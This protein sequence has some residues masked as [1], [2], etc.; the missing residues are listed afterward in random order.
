MIN[1]GGVMDDIMK[2]FITK[3]I[4]AD[5]NMLETQYNTINSYYKY[6]LKISVMKA[7]DEGIVV[8]MM[9][10]KGITANHKVPINMPFILVPSNASIKAI[11][12]ID[13]YASIDEKNHNR[14]M[15]DP[16]KLYC[17]LESAFVARGLQ[18]G[19]SSVRHNTILY[20]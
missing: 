20:F 4:V 3:G 18:L 19:F 1:K 13:N 11:A 17:L 2:T 5:K 10:P 9:Y 15:I 7:V 8:P 6:P 12:V 16:N 14:I